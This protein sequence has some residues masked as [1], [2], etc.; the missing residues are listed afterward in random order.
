MKAQSQNPLFK[1]AEIRVSY[2]PKFKA[3]ERP[4]VTQSSDAYKVLINNWDR[5]MLQLCEQC[6]I[7]LLNQAN[8]VIGMREIS[9][10][11]FAMAIVDPKIVFSIALK[12]CACAIVIAHSHPSGSLKPSEADFKMTARMVEAGKLLD[13]VVLDHL[14]VTKNGYFSFGDEGLI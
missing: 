4:K 12:G 2:Q 8:Q 13:L 1:I 7:M 10:G 6:Y 14:I 9:R 5:D 11:G 3:S